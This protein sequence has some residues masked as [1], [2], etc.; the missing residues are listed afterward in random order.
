MWIKSHCGGYKLWH[1]SALLH[2][3]YGFFIF[4]CFTLFGLST[5]FASNTLAEVTTW[6][7]IVEEGV[8]LPSFFSQ[9][10][11]NYHHK[12]PD[13]HC[14]SYRDAQQRWMSLPQYPRSAISVEFRPGKLRNEH[15]KMCSVR[16]PGKNTYRNRRHNWKQLENEGEMRS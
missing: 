4:L 8:W 6:H 15:Q 13:I 11:H 16:E 7:F 5:S 9:T 14:T 3:L 12:C 1:L 10:N 2:I